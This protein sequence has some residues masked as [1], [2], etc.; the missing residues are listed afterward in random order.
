[1]DTFRMIEPPDASERNKPANSLPSIGA[2]GHQR[3]IDAST[4]GAN[5]IH[6][7]QK[8]GQ[9]SGCKQTIFSACS[10]HRAGVERY[11]FG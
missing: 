3:A 11:N 6:A 7:E 1:M 8:A 2:V 10:L 5:T 4:Q 9:R